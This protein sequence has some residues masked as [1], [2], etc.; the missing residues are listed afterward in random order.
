MYYEER[1][2]L[3][4]DD[5]LNRLKRKYQEYKSEYYLY[6]KKTFTEFYSSMLTVDSQSLYHFEHSFT[7]LHWSIIE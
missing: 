7:F 6:K 2:R 4:Y 1:E 3:E 5:V